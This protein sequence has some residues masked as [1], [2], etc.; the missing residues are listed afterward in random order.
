MVGELLRLTSAPVHSSTHGK[1]CPTAADKALTSWMVDFWDGV[2]SEYHIILY[3][4][5]LYHIILYYIILYYIILYYII[6]YYIILYYIILYYIILYYIILYYIILYYI[7]LYYIIL[8]Y[9]MICYVL[10]YHITSYYV[11]CM[12]F[13]WVLTLFFHA[14]VSLEVCALTLHM[15]YKGY[16][17][18]VYGKGPWS[19]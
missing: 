19:G 15:L 16:V 7:I 9:I 1:T 17:G 6:L 14:W 11:K 13:I 4:I 10:L 8:S 5:I 3:H 2:Q 18:M 12:P